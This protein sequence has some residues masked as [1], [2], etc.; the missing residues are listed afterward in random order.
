[1]QY[2]EKEKSE[3]LEKAGIS[4]GVWEG[5]KKTPYQSVSLGTF[6]SVN[7]ATVE[8]SKALLLENVARI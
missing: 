2:R 6:L 1:V 8:V 3:L 7:L 4:L 5:S